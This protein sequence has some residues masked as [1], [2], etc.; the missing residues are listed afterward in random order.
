M[1]VKIVRKGI[2]KIGVYWAIKLDNKKDIIPVASKINLSTPQ[3]VQVYNEY[4]DKILKS[5]NIS[6]NVNFDILICSPMNFENEV[7]TVLNKI[8]DV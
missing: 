7:E 5:Q 6:F 2:C 3:I 4:L 1:M 8:K